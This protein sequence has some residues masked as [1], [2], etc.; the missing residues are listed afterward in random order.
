MTRKP[1]NIAA[2]ILA[3]GES[4]RFGMPKQNLAYGNSTL[5]N[6]IKEQLNADFVE[7]TFVVLGAY[8]D[9]IIQECGLREDEY[10]LFK[11]WKNGMGSSLAYACKTIF[12]KEKYDGLLITLSDLPLVSR[13]DYETLIRL[14]KDEKD[15]VA[16]KSGTVLGVPSLFGYAYFDELQKLKGEKGARLLLQ[17]HLKNVKEVANESAMID[18]DTLKDYQNLS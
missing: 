8:A 13:S 10:I 18:V 7:R 17:K 2:L 11:D 3:A 4:S 14:F 9:E 1:K 12:E 16:T 5:L 6:H 15:I